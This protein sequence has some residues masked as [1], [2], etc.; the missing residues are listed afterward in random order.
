VCP[1]DRFML[2]SDGI[3]R[4]LDE[5]AIRRCLLMSDFRAAAHALIEEAMDAGSSD[6]VTAVVIEAGA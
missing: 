5:P 3:T 1:G 4:S 2:C 6:N